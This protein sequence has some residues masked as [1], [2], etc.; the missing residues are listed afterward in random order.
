MKI[1]ERILLGPLMAGIW[2][3]SPAMAAKAPLSDEGLRD[4]AQLIV[5][6]RITRIRIE[7][8]SSTYEGP[9]NW[10]WAIYLSLAV[11][12]VEKGDFEAKSL[13]ARCFRIKSRRSLTEYLT[14]GGHDPIPEAGT[15]V[16]AHLV[17]G[18][19]S[20]HVLEPN[21]IVP[22]SNITPP[23]APIAPSSKPGASDAKQVAE[24]RS[25]YYTYLLP[26]EVWL[27]VVVVG[28]AILAV[29]GIIRKRRN[30]NR[31]LELTGSNES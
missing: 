10:D 2:L 16:T 24:L 21:G 31:R 26:L 15:R 20:W 4:E 13:E 17:K 12:S 22:I 19:E 27:L 30:L 1:A 28:A 9:G 29:A 5:V 8:E 14:P 6:A 18:P 23:S 7:T 11:E 3:S 25:G